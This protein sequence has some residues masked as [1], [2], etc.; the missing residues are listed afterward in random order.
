M[1]VNNAAENSSICANDAFLCTAEPERAPA[2]GDCAVPPG[3]RQ[4]PAVST[5]A[6]LDRI[7]WEILRA[8][9]E[10]GRLPNN[11]LAAC[12]GIA[13]STCIKRL[14]S[15]R[16]RGV[17]RGF[18]AEIDLEAVGRPLQAMIAIRVHRHVR[19]DLDVFRAAVQKLPH[20]VAVYATSGANDYLVHV[21]VPS[22]D[23]LRELVFADLAE[24]PAVAHAETALIFE[25]L[26]TTGVIT[27]PP[28]AP[29][30]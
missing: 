13:P 21:A 4:P 19:Q 15:L 29:Q 8:L 12:V 10:N 7:D 27:T 6:E 5:G 18:R 16:A 17:I 23:S 3:S 28:P 1:I 14:R 25:R 26:S 9:E 22:A 20:I 11:K 24:L 2:G 30:T